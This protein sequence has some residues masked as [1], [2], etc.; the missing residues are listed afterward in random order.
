MTGLDALVTELEGL[1]PLR[2]WGSVEA[3]DSATLTVRGLGPAARRGDRLRV[4][5]QGREPVMAEIVA[6][7]GP[8]ATAMWFGSGDGVAVGDRAWLE[9]P[10]ALRPGPGW[11]GRVVDA[12]GRPMDGRPMADGVREAP[13]KRPPPPPA[14]RRGLGPRLDTGL[15]VFDTLLPL[16]QGQRV[17][18]FAGSGVGKSTLLGQL[19]RGVRADV[20][21]IG[22]IGERGREVRDFVEHVLGPEGLARS[23]VVAA[24]ADQSPLAKRQAA[25]TA[26]AVAETFRDCGLQVLLLIDSLTRFAEAHREVALAAG[27]APSLRAYPPSTAHAIASLVE[28]AGPGEGRQGDVTAIYSVLVAGSDME[29]PVAD[30]TRGAIDGH[31][32][33]ERS[34]AERGRFPAVDVRRSVSRSLPGCATP[35]ENAKI[36]EARR[37]IGAYEEVEPMIRTGLYQPGADPLVDRAV[38][39]HPAL[40]FFTTMSLDSAAMSFAALGEALKT[41]PEAEGAPGG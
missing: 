29:E 31:V 4:I 26:T 27:E 8:E 22:L 10:G 28:R 2:L 7:R 24:T 13:L 41:E 34:I 32:I 38:A 1:R 16:C 18:L 12:F 35:E 20:A 40:D 37:L 14:L 36:V 9:G 21:V 30:I 23:V 5:P 15:A 3:V 39:A 25:W 11:I 19:A 6:L 33:L 17:G